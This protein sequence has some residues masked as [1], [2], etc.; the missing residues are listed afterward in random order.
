MCDL[1]AH[2]KL[3]EKSYQD[4]VQLILDHSAPKPSE[5]VQR[6]KFN[7]R[8]R[9]E[10]ESVAGF[11]AALR[12][13][14]EHC[15]YNDT[16]ETVLRD[17]IVCADHIAEWTASDPVLQQVLRRVQQ[18]WGDKC[19]DG[20]LQPFFVRRD[21]LSTHN[22]CILWGNRVIFPARG[23]RQLLQ[24]LHATH[25]GM[26][27]MKN[28]ARSYLW[29]PGLDTDIEGRWSSRMKYVTCI[30]PHLLLH[31]PSLGMA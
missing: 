23:Q 13:L 25:P 12:N 10:G 2:V 26:A 27:R 24:D 3:G 14:A 8:F 17:R 19:P 15:G 4:L 5:I 29:W 7:N 11:V 1:L 6:C 21:E 28:L 18:G 9:N 31:P 16:L 20:S 30:V 22:G